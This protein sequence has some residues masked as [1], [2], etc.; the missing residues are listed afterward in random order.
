VLLTL[1]P[2]AVPFLLGSVLRV[3]S[4]LS[5]PDPA[6]I[7]ANVQKLLD[8]S[9]E[10]AQTLRA[11][12][13]RDGSWL[14]LSLTESEQTPLGERR[15]AYDEDCAMLAR[16]AAVVFATWISNEHPEFLVALTP[17]GAPPESKPASADAQAT[18]PAEALAPP[19]SIQSSLPPSDA[20]SRTT[21]APSSLASAPKEPS[22]EARTREPR[23]ATERH[24]V[25]GAG[26][27]G[28]ASSANLAP[29]LALNAAWDPA[30]R[31]LGIR[32]SANWFGARTEALGSGEVRWTRW[33]LLAGPFL[34]VRAGRS[35]LDLEA[36]LALGWARVSG[37]NFA[38]NT[39]DSGVTF[40]TYAGLHFVPVRNRPRFFVN[41]T[42]LFWF[43]EATA[44][45]TDA[46]G[47]T[48]SR[49][50]PS[51]EALFTLGTELPL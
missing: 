10:S 32:V 40:G 42:P 8:L 26:L 12:A 33:P 18:A 45:A 3:Q 9:D 30:G 46:S 23:S 2:P 13:R 44:V 29:A 14:V 37:Q 36:G 25:L 35:N 19:A 39:T 21:T 38:G 47:A 51:F 15:V 7:S 17:D 48:I 4:E 27:G 49:S 16:T 28:V 11:T 5:C 20:T 24:W 34:R 6:E 22:H 1:L 50:L 31:G 41:A 43:R